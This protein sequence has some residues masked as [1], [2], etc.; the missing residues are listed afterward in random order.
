MDQKSGGFDFTAFLGMAL[1]EKM[2]ESLDSPNK[3]FICITA[4]T[5]MSD[6]VAQ[7]IQQAGTICFC[8]INC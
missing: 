7:S 6:R 5:P 8:F 1:A 3:G 4:V 2:N